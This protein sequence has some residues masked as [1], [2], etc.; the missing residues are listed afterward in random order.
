MSAPARRPA[1][2]AKLPARPLPWDPYDPRMPFRDLPRMVV[3]AVRRIRGTA[4]IAN[5]DSWQYELFLR[6]LDRPLL[7]A[8]AASGGQS[9]AVLTERIR[10]I[11]A[12]QTRPS[13]TGIRA[14]TE[15]TA[16]DWLLSAWRRGLVE[17]L[18]AEPGGWDTGLAGPL[19]TLTDRGR[20]GVRAPAA[21]VLRRFPAARVLPIVTAGAGGIYAWANKH[22]DVAAVLGAYVA[23]AAG[24]VL[25]LWVTSAW[26]D[27]RAA[28]A[29]LVDIE[30][31]R[32]RGEI[33]PVLD[34]RADPAPGA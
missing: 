2:Q 23:L 13:R 4:V 18:P 26:V 31:A 11:R 3:W 9:S 34:A 5:L 22:A 15:P 29:A 24:Y 17:P 14:M 32:V 27:R 30:T 25:V 21:R 19:W 33:P 28:R 10:R 6:H 16:A 1:N 12:I 7:R 20:E 8:L